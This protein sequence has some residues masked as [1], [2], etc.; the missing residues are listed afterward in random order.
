[1]GSSIGS[2]VFWVASLAFAFYCY[3]DLQKHSD[4]T[5]QAAGTPKQTA[6]I[7]IIVGGVCCWL[8]LVYYWFAIKP[9]AD[10]AEQGGAGGYPGGYP[11]AS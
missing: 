6:L 9:K 11:P 8:G 3:Q 5:M 1:M 7:I 4:E 10:A 2:L